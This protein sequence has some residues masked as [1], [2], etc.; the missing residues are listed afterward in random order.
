MLVAGLCRTN[1]NRQ[2]H[3]IRRVF[4]WAVSKEMIPS[5]VYEALTTLQA[6][7]V[8]RSRARESMP[9]SAVPEEIVE[10]T[11]PQLTSVV[12]AMVK[13]QLLTGMRPGEVCSL[14][15]RCITFSKSGVW[16]PGKN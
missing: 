6:L 13:T 11:L 1:I 12:Q 2:M 4:K 8:G 5:S 16:P 14:R 9:V 3:R 7:K 15:P 10:A